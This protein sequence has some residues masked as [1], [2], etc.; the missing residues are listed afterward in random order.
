MIEKSTSKLFNT[1][2]ALLKVAGRKIHCISGK[3]MNF[4]ITE[5]NST[6]IIK[7]NGPMELHSV[8]DLQARIVEINASLDKNVEVDLADVDYIDSTG[9]SVLIMLHRQQKQKGKS[10]SIKNATPRVSNL[11]DLSSL[12]ELLRQ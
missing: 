8:K 3:L 11:L 9:I 10:L 6:M 4:N 5:D 2:F 1:V 7:I 12:S